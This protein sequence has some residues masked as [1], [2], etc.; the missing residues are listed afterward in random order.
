MAE[1]RN[2]NSDP[3]KP[4]PTMSSAVLINGGA[5]RQGMPGWEGGNDSEGDKDSVDTE[6]KVF[7]PQYSRLA[8][9]CRRRSAYPRYFASIVKPEYEG[10]P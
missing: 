9:E 10:V 3:M 2:G 6:V 7:A 5:T 4:D 8:G 1:N